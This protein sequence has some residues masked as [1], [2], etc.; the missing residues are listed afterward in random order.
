MPENKP[1]KLTPEQ[2]KRQAVRKKRKNRLTAVILLAFL[3]LAV[4]FF[5]LS[6]CFKVR[7]IVIES[8]DK[9]VIYTAEQGLDAGRALGLRIGSPLF[10]FD[11]GALE[12]KAKTVLGDFDS[13]DIRR[14]LPS[15]VVLR[16]TE[17]K[18]VF[19]TVFGNQTYLLSKELRVIRRLDNAAEAEKLALKRVT[20]SSVDRCI[21]GE[22]LTA[23]DGTDD[24]FRLLCRV[25]EEEN[26]FADCDAFDLTDRF[27]VR[28]TY[29]TRFTAL[30]GD[31]AEHDY[32]VAKLRYLRAIADDRPENEGSFIDVSDEDLVEGSVKSYS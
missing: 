21:C 25:L 20:F 4:S 1:K 30:I 23:G 3:V 16:V 17:A 6:K 31:A 12:K 9:S 11:T 10:A 22:Y 18:P 8:G 5:A 24:A 2:A 32:L 15:T 13:V 26:M 14:R 27:N 19:C 7:S 28:F 29:R